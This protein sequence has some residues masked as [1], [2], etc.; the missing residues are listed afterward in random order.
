MRIL[1]IARNDLRIK[2]RDRGAIVSLF[3]EMNRTRT[4]TVPPGWTGTFGVPG[5]RTL[6]LTT[7]DPQSGAGPRSAT[8]SETPGFVPTRVVRMEIE[9]FNGGAIDDLRFDPQ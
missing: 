8:A 3:D 7:L 4:Y 5:V 2:L 1:H 6:D 9:L